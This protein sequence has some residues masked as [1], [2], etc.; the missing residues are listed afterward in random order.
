M[1]SSPWV[2]G[3]GTMS[4]TGGYGAV[5]FEDAVGVL[6][7]AIDTGVALLD[8]ADAYPNGERLVATALAQRPSHS[9]HVATKIGLTG[10]PGAR[11]PCG[12]STYLRHACE[13]SLRRLRTDSVDVLLLHRVDDTVPVEDSI[14]TLGALVD[15]GKAQHIG[16][17]TA[18]SQIVR[19]AHTERALSFV[20]TE[21][22]ILESQPM[23]D[24]VP[25]AAELGITLMAHS[26]LRRG[27]LARRDLPRR[28]ASD[29]AR[30]YIPYTQDPE[31]RQAADA[32]HDLAS[33]LGV[34]PVKLA[35]GWLLSQPCEVIP[36]PG[37]RKCVQAIVN[38]TGQVAPR[39]VAYAEAI[40]AFIAGRNQEENSRA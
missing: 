38:L 12:R 5:T 6:L 32:F 17:C 39:P 31:E 36:L 8:T 14:G 13:S 20:Q 4:L 28:F 23:H 29:D 30:S 2:P 24:L 37:A 27:L 40:A 34:E 7:C 26:P 19:R 11:V 21:F 16:I 1:M 25:L 18:S 15:E 22:S 9:V 35:L 33:R 10:P 3:L